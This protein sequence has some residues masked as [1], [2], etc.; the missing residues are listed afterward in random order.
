[1]ASMRP[2]F[3]PRPIDP[4]KPLP[5]FRSS[6]DLRHA[7]DQVVSRAL[8]Q[9]GTGVEAA[10]L[11]ERHLQQALLTN[12]YGADVK[13]D[14]P[15]P[16][17]EEVAP[18]PRKAKGAKYKRPT[19]Y[20]MFDRSDEDL[21]EAFVD[22]DGDFEDEAF[23]EKYNLAHRKQAIPL[24]MDSLERAM[25]VLEKLQGR[26]YLDAVDEEEDEDY[27][28][29]VERYDSKKGATAAAKRKPKKKE[30]VETR[31]SLL[32]FSQVR[33]ELVQ[34][35]PTCT[36]NGRRELYMHWAERRVAHRGPFH[37]LYIQPPSM[38]NHNPAIA[39]RPRGREDGGG[40]RRM[41]TFENFKRARLLREEFELLRSVMEAVVTRERAKLD[42]ISVA[43]ANQ[44]I[45]CVS[46]GGTRL[47]TVSRNLALGDREGFNIGP[48]E[49]GIVVSCRDLSLPPALESLLGRKTFNV[50]KAR[51]KKKVTKKA[52]TRDSK[53]AVGDGYGGTAGI[54][55]PSSRGKDDMDGHNLR[56]SPGTHQNA[57]DAYGYD[58]HANKFLK[59]MRYF[60]GG[61][62]N[63][64]VC[65]YDHRVF[66]AASERNTNKPPVREPKPFIFPSPAVAFASQVRPTGGKTRPKLGKPVLAQPL[67]TSHLPFR[68]PTSPGRPGGQG[69]R[70]GARVS[71]SKP[72]PIKVRG[73]VGR[74][75]R[76]VLDRVMYQAER[77]VKAASYPASVEMGG[78]FTAGL[79]LEVACR[80][81][82]EE[83]SSG[84]MGRLSELGSTVGL[85][86]EQ[87]RLVRPLEPLTSLAEGKLGSDGQQ[88]YWPSK[89]RARRRS[90]DRM[91]VDTP[92]SPPVL[93]SMTA[94]GKG[95]STSASQL[96]KMPAY[97]TRAVSLVQPY[98]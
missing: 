86:R 27:E 29:V 48:A 56:Q 81:G 87:A 52:P 93:R 17:F 28:D 83:A 22:Y 53:S 13:I 91:D 35:L 39:F 16:V 10:E 78:T 44:R 79:P 65:P 47:A 30:R 85:T 40:G 36:D 67:A 38:D 76:L 77:G 11:Q 94:G 12:M 95:K 50:D 19:S 68:P 51:S 59:H 7:D 54:G 69:S 75:G 98:D 15:I 26:A 57:V 70:F 84:T 14:I 3:R 32:Q 42:A 61:F 63:Y 31:D 21:E 43:A 24:D 6:S 49:G 71:I 72:R 58:A 45:D 8:P 41:N 5:I 92:P 88:V 64:G 20:I 90:N 80:V 25:D 89:L 37:R 73:R 46:S 18:P 62:M 1:M 74:G 4:S 82:A 2:S 96:R 66:A 9:V 33:S 60:A 55:N 23:V 97:T 34:V